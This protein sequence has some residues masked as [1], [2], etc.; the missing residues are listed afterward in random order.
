[1]K[2]LITGASG[3]VGRELLR[4]RPPAMQVQAFTHGQL[5]VSDGN[6]VRAVIEAFQPALIIN[7]AAYTAVDRAESDPD[8]AH[9]VNVEGPRN[10]ARAASAIAACRLLHISTDYVFDGAAA[11]PY[12]P[13]DITHP[14]NVYGRTKLLGEQVVRDILQERCAVLRTSWVYAPQG[15]NF[16]LTMLRLMREQGRVRVVADQ[17]GCPTAASSV[18]TALWRLGQLTPLHGIFHWTDAG[19]VSWHGFACAIAE[20]ALAL[21]LLEMRP[22]VIA[23][24]TSEYPT[25]APR[26]KCSAL[27]TLESGRQLGLEPLPWR[28]NL[29]AVLSSLTPQ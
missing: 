6:T 22:E 24:E 12:R 23:I 15:R 20:A 14:L 7:A 28:D 17:T 5:D 16:V 10:L 11:A 26:P 4:A 25:A 27:D 8:R 2:V 18:A 9:A 3:Q 29:R 13:S 21:K 19:I 1:V